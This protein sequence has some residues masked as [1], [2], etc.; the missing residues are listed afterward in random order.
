M[1]SSEEL[2]A[3]EAW[4]EQLRVE[5]D[6]DGVTSDPVAIERLTGMLA[7]AFADWRLQTGYIDQRVRPTE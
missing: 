5:L 7:D 3:F 4:L 6:E 1:S 2:Q